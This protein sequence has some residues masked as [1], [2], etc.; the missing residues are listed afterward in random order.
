VGAEWYDGADPGEGLATPMT[1]TDGSFSSNSEALR[2]TLPALSGGTHTLSVRALDAA[3][4]W[5][6]AAH[7]TVTMS[8]PVVFA[9]SFAAGNLSAWTSATGGSAISATVAAKLHGP[10][11]YGLQ[12]TQAGTAQRFVLDNRPALESQYSARFYFNPHGA[13]PG[14]SSPTILAAIKGGGGT[15]MR[16]QYGRTGAG[17]YRIRAGALSGSTWR[18]SSWYTISNAAHAIEVDWKAGAGSGSLKLLVDG[19]LKQTLG[20][21]VN[22]SHRIDKVKLGPSATL[23]AGDSGVLYF[24]DFVSTRGGTIG[25]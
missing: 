21:L 16:V 6:P 15:V 7:V 9:N 17:V 25:P 22:G 23:A 10:D 13:L 2:A 11:S 24:D 5:G 20:S 8:N 14:S 12:A 18:N 4:N 1:A 3:G 19:T